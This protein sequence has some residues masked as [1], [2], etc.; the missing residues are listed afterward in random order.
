ME[1]VINLRPSEE[2]LYIT[3][4]KYKDDQSLIVKTLG[5]FSNIEHEINF[6][7][8]ES[9]FYINST[10]VSVHV[11]EVNSYYEGIDVYKIVGVE[12]QLIVHADSYEMTL[13]D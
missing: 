11:D 3:D 2:S 7:S 12:Y 6:D 5:A 13:L 1:R 9:F 4:I 10:F 8:A